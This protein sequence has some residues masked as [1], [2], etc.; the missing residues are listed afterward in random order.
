MK[1]TTRILLFS[2]LIFSLLITCFVIFNS[3][4]SDNNIII[5]T[6]IKPITIATNEICKGIPNVSVKEITNG[7]MDSNSCFHDFSLTTKQVKDIEKSLLTII[8]GVSFEPFMKNIKNKNIIDSS[9]NVNIIESNKEK[10]PWIWMS[11]KNYIEQVRNIFMGLIGLYEQGDDSFSTK[12][13]DKMFSNYTRYKQDLE[14]IYWSWKPKFE[15]FRGRKVLTVSDE[16][17]Y[18]LKELELNPVHLIEGHHHGGMSTKSVSNAIK[19]IKDGNYKF[20]LSSSDK[21]CKLFGQT[22]AKCV[23]LDLIKS[24]DKISYIEEMTKNLNLLFDNLKETYE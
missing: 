22:N 18:L 3:Q 12:D 7:Y 10:N 8:N 5:L 17:D 21:Y 16:F 15:E 23:R 6:T 19:I 11:I 20:Y 14:N 4:K 13:S 24:N 9:Q 2:L 1:T